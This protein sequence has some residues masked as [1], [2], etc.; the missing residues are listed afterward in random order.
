M[1]KEVGKK[2][3]GALGVLAAA[4]VVIVLV[5]VCMAPRPVVN[6]VTEE[7]RRRVA[8]VNTIMAGLKSAITVTVVIFA[9][10][11]AMGISG[12]NT[13]AMLVSAGVVGLVIGFGAQSLIRSYLAGL[14]SLTTNRLNIGDLVRLDVMGVPG[15][16]GGGDGFGAGGAARSVI[17]GSGG[18]D[19]R[20]PG[21]SSPAF[22]IVR[23]FTLLTTT[24]ED[25]RGAQTYVSNGNILMITNYSQNP[26]RATVLVHVD[27]TNDPEVVRKGL[28]AF[29]EAMALEEPLRDR[30]LRP[31]SVKGI[32]G[33]GENSY[34]I[35][36]TALANPSATLWVERYIRQRLLHYLHS[37]GIRGSAAASAG[38][39]SRI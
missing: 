30:V 31:P 15:S 24:L 6:C 28:D 8:R 39:A 18:T 33:T 25:L 14:V 23:N 11:I 36:V 9:V 16:G 37:I 17:G 10:F 22:G 4:I 35:A 32:T 26:Q 29:V 13:R 19:G 12:V 20:G 5:N 2:V 27:H 3:G 38:S 34:V 21:G 1:N 7:D